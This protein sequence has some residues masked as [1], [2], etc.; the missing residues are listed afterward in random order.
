VNDALETLAR[1]LPAGASAYVDRD[2][3]TDGAVAPP[4]LRFIPDEGFTWPTG[5]TVPSSGDADDEA[6]R[7]LAALIAAVADAVPAGGSVLVSGTGAVAQGVRT[8]L[9]SRAT[10][11]ADRPDTIVETT[12]HPE[13]I[14]E[15]TER[16]ADLGCVVLAATPR[17]GAMSF[18]LYP[19]IHRRGLR[20]VGV[21]DPIAA[22]PADARS[23]ALAT[24]M[25]VGAW[26]DGATWLAV[27][28]PA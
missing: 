13:A 4:A 15:A 10:A 26:S 25:A 2:W 7:L 19:D 16:V 3:L 22:G 5:V 23:E 21:P 14:T 12:G 18:D 28:A 1:E 24:R 6:A 8:A 11:E 17:G 20:V 27:R 9:G